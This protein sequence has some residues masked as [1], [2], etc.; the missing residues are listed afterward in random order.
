MEDVTHVPGFD[1]TSQHLGQIHDLE[2]ELDRTKRKNRRT[3]KQAME[4]QRKE[5]GHTVGLIIGSLLC[6]LVASI[7]LG[8]VIK[9]WEWVL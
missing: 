4:D 1:D 6:L 7:I 9:F 8:L 5:H 3:R 2:S